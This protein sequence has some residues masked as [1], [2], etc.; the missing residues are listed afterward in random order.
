M[1]AADV[2]DVETDSRMVIAFR[3]EVPTTSGYCNGWK[4]EKPWNEVPIR[5]CQKS[6]KVS[7]CSLCCSNIDDT[8]TFRMIFAAGEPKK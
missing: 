5:E 1:V 3:R 7:V 8:L 6:R 4:D 2:D